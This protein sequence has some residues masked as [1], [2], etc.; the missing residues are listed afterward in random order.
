MF[1]FAEL[2]SL[3]VLR[4]FLGKLTMYS[5]DAKGT[6]KWFANSIS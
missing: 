4:V 2:V 6:H 5:K 3:A 1:T